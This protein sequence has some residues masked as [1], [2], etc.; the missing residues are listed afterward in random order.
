MNNCGCK[1]IIKSFSDYF[2]FRLLLFIMGLYLNL[3]KE[4]KKCECCYVFIEE[5]VV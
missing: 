4:W 2:S 3:N 5:L 1:G